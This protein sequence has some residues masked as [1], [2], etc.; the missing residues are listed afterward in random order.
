MYKNNSRVSSEFKG[1]SPQSV[2][3]L[4]FAII[5]KTKKLHNEN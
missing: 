4:M 5:L 3:I 1:C 2:T